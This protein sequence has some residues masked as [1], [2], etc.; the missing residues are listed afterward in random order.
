VNGWL[1]AATILVAALVPLLAVAA[2]RPPLEA[3]VAL[4]VAGT[5]SSAAL[6]VLAEGAN[7]Q[8]FADLALAL[9]LLSFAGAV[10]F[11]RFL[12]RVP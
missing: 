11:L 6:L 3:L 1:W 12:E 2:R 8:A 4:E 5:L 10:T 9:G 7:R